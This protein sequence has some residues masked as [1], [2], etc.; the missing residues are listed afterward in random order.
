MHVA[1]SVFRLVQG[2]CSLVIS[3]RPCMFAVVCVFVPYEAVCAV[4]CD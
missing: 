2:M 4:C 1:E 3:A